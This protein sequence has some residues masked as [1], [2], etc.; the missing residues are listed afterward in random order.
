MGKSRFS[1]SDDSDLEE[2]DLL[3]AFCSNRD[4]VAI[5]ADNYLYM[6]CGHQICS[7]C[8]VRNR[9]TAQPRCPT[10][11]TLFRR[12]QL[13]R[14]TV[15][16]QEYERESSVRRKVGAVYNRPRSDFASAREFNDYL[17]RSEEMV[18]RL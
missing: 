3:C 8:Q 2:E 15:E 5:V 12:T 18:H 13:S 11:D 4:V 17:E 14:K 9:G 1:D 10:C 7:T 16:Q 6:P